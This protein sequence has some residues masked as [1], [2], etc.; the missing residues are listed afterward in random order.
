M[1]DVYHVEEIEY[2]ASSG[3]HDP[4]ASPQDKKLPSATLFLNLIF[5]YLP[6]LSFLDPPLKCARDCN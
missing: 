2:W 3:D 6:M 4:P 1:P 5:V